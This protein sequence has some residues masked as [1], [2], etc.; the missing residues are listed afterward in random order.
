MLHR[1]GFIILALAAAA[2]GLVVGTLNSD[3]VSVDLL[4][5]Q[6]DW[7]LGLVMLI[8]LVLGA[9]IGM[10]IVWLGTVLPLK[11]HLRRLKGHS[12]EDGRRSIDSSSTGSDD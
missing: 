1:I 2:F 5:I 6:I 4:W 8:C 9:A 7:P 11:I 10:L 12:A 3:A